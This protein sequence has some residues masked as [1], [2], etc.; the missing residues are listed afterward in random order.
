MSHAVALARPHA[1]PVVTA[2]LPLPAGTDPLALLAAMPAPQ[3]FFWQR[4]DVAIAGVGAAW[5]VSAAGP[6]RFARAAD[7][8]AALPDDAIAVGG[9]A[10]DDAPAWR[11]AWRDVPPAVWTVPRFA[12]VRRNGAAHLVGT[13]AP[14]DEVR[15]VARLLARPLPRAT[16]ATRY[17]AV[18]RRG[19]AA[20]RHMVERTLADIHAGRLAKLVLART[21]DVRA[22]RPFDA[23][24]VVDRLRAAY[25][26]CATFAVRVGHATFVGTTPERLARVDGDRLATEALAGTTGRGAG[27]SADR[28]LADA[29]HANA[30]ER[31]EHALVVD[32]V[33]SRLAP[34]CHDLRADP[35]PTL[36]GTETVQHLYTPITGRLRAGRGLLDAVAAL[37]PTAAICGAPRGAARAALRARE[38]FDRGWYGGGVGWIGGG[39]GEVSVALR[40]ALLNGRRATLYAGAGIVA[41]SRWEAELEETRLKLRPM[42]AALLEL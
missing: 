24:R 12:V 33:T 15:R 4:D 37:H 19:A 3:R 35:A 5:T 41:G 42:L 23:V 40:C 10:F 11:G 30:K 16:G 39:A 6:D 26:G 20:W 14:A 25:P 2:S 22:D 17:Q 28:A 34:L 31:A 27:P 8:L 9:F 13:D 38:G 29:L 36:V 7:A 18:V 32:D 1:T 21:A